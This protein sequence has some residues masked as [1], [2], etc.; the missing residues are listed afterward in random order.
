MAIGDQEQ[1]WLRHR[2]PRQI[3]EKVQAG[4]IAPVHILNKE[5]HRGVC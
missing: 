1:E 5:K 3:V 2:A 4:V